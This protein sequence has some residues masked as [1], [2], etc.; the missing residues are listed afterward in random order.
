MRIS[1]RMRPMG[2][3]RKIPRSTFQTPGVRNWLRRL[4][5]NPATLAP[6][7]CEKSDLSYQGSVLEPGVPVGLGSPSTLMVMN[8]PW[9]Q[10]GQLSC[11]FVP[12]IENGVPEYAAPMPLIC[13]FLTMRPRML[14]ESFANGSS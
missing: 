9:P 5:P 7:G 10:P 8:W 3:E 2:N 12:V 14:L 6:V 11:G 4:F 13:Q 1:G